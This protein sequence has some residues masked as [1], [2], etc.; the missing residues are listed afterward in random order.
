MYRYSPTFERMRVSVS[1][2]RCG[3]NS[4]GLLIRLYLDMRLR[5]IFVCLT[6]LGDLS[7]LLFIGQSSPFH[8]GCVFWITR[9]RGHRPAMAFFFCP[10]TS[11]QSSRPI[12]SK[13]EERVPK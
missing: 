4:S 3:G 5:F 10:K 9:G 8:H 6:F 1:W 12:P 11:A 2:K 7:Y 13:D